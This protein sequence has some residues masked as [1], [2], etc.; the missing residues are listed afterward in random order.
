MTATAIGF[1]YDAGSGGKTLSAAFTVCYVT[2]C[3][4][5][6]LAV[7]QSGLFTAVIQP[8]LILFVAV[9]TAFFLFHGSEIN[10]VKD[11]L[12]NCGYPLIERFP[13]MFFTAAT[14][15]VIGVARWYLNSL[16]RRNQPVEAPDG[17]DEPTPRRASRR[18]A[19]RAA[20]AEPAEEAAVE[21]PARR[22]RRRPVEPAVDAVEDEEA[23][24]PRRPRTASAARSRHARPAETEIIEPVQARPRRSRPPVDP[25]AEPR[26]RPRSTD[27]TRDRRNLPPVERRSERDR[28][29]RAARRDRTDRPVRRER[30]DRYERGDRYD[31]PDRGARS[32]RRTRMPD[33]EPYEN[34][35]GYRP[36][37]AAGPPVGTNGSG[38]HH[39]ISRVRY[40]AGD[41]EAVGESPRRPQRRTRSTDA[42]SWEYDV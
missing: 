15:L 27:D 5:A 36:S 16:A 10:G 6:V 29:E 13:L 37:A 18:S 3:I 23:P 38:T 39:P 4:L 8:A 17:D 14:V 30:E 42:D 28:Q 34:Y 40:R 12:I 19:A 21:T 26:R 24:R 7:R 31:R 11:I 33:Y 9:P 1:A 32:E 35:D 20:A 41:D 25:G 2:G 22:S